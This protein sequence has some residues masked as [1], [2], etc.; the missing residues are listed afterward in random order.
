MSL[1]KNYFIEKSYHKKGFF[2]LQFSPLFLAI[3]LG[4][5]IA[6]FPIFLP[7]KLPLFYSLPWGGN[8]IVSPQQF[9]IIP[10][11]VVLITLVNLSLS[12]QLHQTQA[13]FKKI[14]IISSF[15]SA[16]I[17]VITIVKIIFIFI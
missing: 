10:A 2:F 17:L 9:F 15:L 4:I 7:N 6:F 8:Q 5:L 16:L 3:I 13:F 12:W 14:L 11:I 1:F